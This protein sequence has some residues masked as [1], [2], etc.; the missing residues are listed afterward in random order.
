MVGGQV[1]IIFVGGEAFKITP[2]NG[3]EWGMSI[4][5]G[6]ISL[7][8]GVVIRTVPDEWAAALIPHVQIP[9]PNIWPFKGIVKKRRAAAAGD[10]EKAPLSEE[11]RRKVAENSDSDAFEAPEAPLRT[12]TSIRGRRATTH[13]R[14]SFREYMHDQKTKVKVKAKVIGGSK[15]DVSSPPQA[16][17]LGGKLPETAA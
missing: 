9:L 6:A 15:T 14:R 17:G 1:L 5:L 2:L 8:W 4:G 3:T 16:P 12:L 13:I 11:E 10:A 7:P